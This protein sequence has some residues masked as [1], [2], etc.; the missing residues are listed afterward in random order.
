MRVHISI[1]CDADPYL[2]PTQL[3]VIRSAADSYNAEKRVLKAVILTIG[4]SR[5]LRTG[6]CHSIF[7]AVADTQ[8]ARTRRPRG[9]RL[10]I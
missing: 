2:V 4:S 7:S 3:K 6:T 10:V 9:M 8:L 1:I 5:F